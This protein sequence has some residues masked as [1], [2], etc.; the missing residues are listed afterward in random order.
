MI[1]L[2]TACGTSYEEQECAPAH[3]KICEDERQFVPASG[4]QWISPATLRATRTPLPVPP[5]SG[6]K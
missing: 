5:F 3:C 1:T 4:Q 6:E 2:C